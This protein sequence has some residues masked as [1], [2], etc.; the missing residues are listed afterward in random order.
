MGVHHLPAV[1]K[2]PNSKGRQCIE[3]STAEIDSQER[4]YA[5]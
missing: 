4:H 1:P 5:Y 2:P 3:A